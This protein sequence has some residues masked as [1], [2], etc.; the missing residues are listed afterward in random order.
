MSKIYSQLK[1]LESLKKKGQQK[2]GVVLLR[3]NE[4]NFKSSSGTNHGHKRLIFAE[5]AIT[6]VAVMLFV[7]I[8]INIKSYIM[9]KNFVS[10]DIQMSKK[11]YGIQKTID[12]QAGQ[13]EVS[14][15]ALVK[16]QNDLSALNQRLK[17]QMSRIE[18]LENKIDG[19]NHTIAGAVKIKDD[20]LSRVTK[21]E[22][23]K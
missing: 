12:L 3:G 7:L 21:L 11:L 9:M 16:M 8:A 2:Q 4:S 1:H 18:E 6:T 20:L 14:M 13:S 17:G 5:I 22:G 10:E 19:Q 23:G 15:T